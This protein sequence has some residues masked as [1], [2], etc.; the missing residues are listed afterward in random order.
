MVAALALATAPALAAG[1]S[2]A[3]EHESKAGQY[4]ADVAHKAAEKS[5]ADRP[6]LSKEDANYQKAVKACKKLQLS[7]RNTCIS[8]A[9]NSAKLARE[10][11]QEMHT[12]K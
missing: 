8:E 4:P 7:E 1:Q 9:G 11:H 6:A 5:I 3:N 12:K 10:A 2:T